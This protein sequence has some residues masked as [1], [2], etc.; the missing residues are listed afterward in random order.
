MAR[1]TSISN[2]QILEA[3]RE[4]FLEQGFEASTAQI[5]QKAGVSEGSIFK[6]FQTKE[7]LFQAAM[8]I[9]EPPF[10][11][12]LEGRAGVGDVRESL[13]EISVEIIRF[14]R[15]LVP[16]VMR[17]WAHTC[18][19]PM[20][21]T[22]GKESPPLRAHRVLAEYLDEEMERGR[23]RSADAKVMARM[24]IGTLHNFVF[25]EVV[26]LKEEGDAEAFARDMV[27]LIWKGAAP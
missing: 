26:G 8:G 23:L 22:K 16:R 21:I 10:E 25:F 18:A 17:L 2:E 12:L 5:A 24:L 9:P 3:A 1:P 20:E 13:V 4:I 27:D 11:R 14:F 15:V 7:G 19:H 6:R